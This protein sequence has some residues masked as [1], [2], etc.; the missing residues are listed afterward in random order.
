MQ[1]TPLKYSIDHIL[2]I[3][4]F[5]YNII[6]FTGVISLCGSRFME[7]SGVISLSWKDK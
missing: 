2:H 3:S 7:S 4:D 1:H 5:D 6:C